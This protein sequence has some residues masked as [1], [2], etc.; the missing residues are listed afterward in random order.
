MNKFVVLTAGLLL[1]G[2]TT[3]Y[4]VGT[5]SGSTSPE[6]AIAMMDDRLLTLTLSDSQE[7]E[8]Y[9]RG[10]TD[11]TVELLEN[12]HYTRLI[13]DRQQVSFLSQPS[14]A[15]FPTVAGAVAGAMLGGVIAYPKES[16]QFSALPLLQTGLGIFLGAFVGGW[17]G[18]ALT[19]EYRFVFLNPGLEGR[20]A[21]QTGS[22]KHIRTGP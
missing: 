13:F 19:P 22:P 17:I 4:Q 1:A 18:H 21:S 7:H 20:V 3:T 14:D 11:S 12:Q 6:E 2:C 10:I 16:N 9:L 15:S 5:G 8:G